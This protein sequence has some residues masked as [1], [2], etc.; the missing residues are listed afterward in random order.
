MHM[1]VT[2]KMMNLDRLNVGRVILV[3][4]G[5]PSLFHFCRG[6]S[7]K[8]SQWTCEIG[9]TSRAIHLFLLLFVSSIM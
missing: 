6:I 5:F 2:Y 9:Y 7:S 3:L 4:G 8:I 1:L